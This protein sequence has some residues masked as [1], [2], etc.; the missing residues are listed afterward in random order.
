VRRVLVNMYERRSKHGNGNVGI[1]VTGEGRMPNWFTAR[2]MAEDY[3]R[4]YESVIAGA[5]NLQQSQ[6]TELRSYG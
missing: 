6:S 2:R 3:T 4:L 1:G 5:A